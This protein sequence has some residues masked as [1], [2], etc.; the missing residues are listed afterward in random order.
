M[1]ERE[2]VPN[3]ESNEVSSGKCGASIVFREHVARYGVIA[4]VDTADGL[5]RIWKGPFAH[6]FATV[7]RTMEI[8]IHEG[9]VYERYRLSSEGRIV[10]G[11]RCNRRCRW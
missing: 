8:R 3:I 1:S 6:S 7:H 11:R 9:H 10:R 2:D 5:G 4:H